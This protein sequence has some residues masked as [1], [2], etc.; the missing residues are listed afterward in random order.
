[1]LRRTRLKT[2]GLRGNLFLTLVGSST[3]EDVF[4]SLEEEDSLD[5]VPEEGLTPSLP[6]SQQIEHVI[7]GSPLWLIAGGV[8]FWVM[9]LYGPDWGCWLSLVAVGLPL[10][11]FFEY[12][13]TVIVSWNPEQR[14]VE[15]YEGARYN[16]ERWLMFAYTSEPGDRIIV[17]S[18]AITKGDDWY[19][20]FSNRDYWL[21]VKRKD[22]LLVASSKDTEN[23]RYFAKRIKAHL[24]S[25]Q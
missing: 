24:D 23:S 19:D 9:I 18:E 22:G 6:S 3:M 15:V 10:Y 16:Q 8:L 21:V 5:S 17:E 7:H 20:I 11:G 2:G 4:W 25:F 13:K 14:C 12:M 1:M